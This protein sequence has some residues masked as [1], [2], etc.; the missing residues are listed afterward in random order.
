MFLPEADLAQAAGVAEKLR[1]AVEAMSFEGEK[2]F[3][4]TCSIGVTVMHA[5]DADIA[6][7]IRRAD[8]A[9]YEAKGSGRNRVVTRD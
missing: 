9:L 2:A 4:I 3:T 7:I 1:T 8:E 6:S 5:D